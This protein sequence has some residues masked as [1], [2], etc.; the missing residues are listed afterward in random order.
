[1]LELDRV[2]NVSPEVIMIFV[3]SDTVTGRNTDRLA[4]VHDWMIAGGAQR[5]SNFAVKMLREVVSSV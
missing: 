4:V 1:M 5:E 2:N 3:I